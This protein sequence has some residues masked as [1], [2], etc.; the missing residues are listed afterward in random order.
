MKEALGKVLSW[1]EMLYELRGVLCISLLRSRAK[2]CFHI[3][4][5]F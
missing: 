3:W 2:D 5:Y 1:Y 4:E